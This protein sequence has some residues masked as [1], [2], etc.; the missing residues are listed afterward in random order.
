MRVQMTDRDLLLSNCLCAAARI[1]D[2]AGIEDLIQHGADIDLAIQYASEKGYEPELQYLKDYQNKK[3]AQEVE[4]GSTW[5]KKKVWVVTVW[6]AEQDED[7]EDLN[8]SSPH[9]DYYADT[10]EEALKM[11]ARFLS[12]IDE[13]YGDWV[14]DVWISDEPEE[15]ELLNCQSASVKDKHAAEKK[16]EKQYR[17]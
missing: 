4:V 3:K 11:K 1:R 9:T 6:L 5:I 12:G 13:Y 15:I 2:N 10:Y 16:S 8:W 7:G 14:E 17:R